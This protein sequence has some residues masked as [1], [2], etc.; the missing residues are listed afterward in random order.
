MRVRVQ[1]LRIE[2]LGR[3]K[4]NRSQKLSWYI[5]IYIYVYRCVYEYDLINVIIRICKNIVKEKE[6]V[7]IWGRF[8]QNGYLCL[9]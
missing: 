9:R 6:R 3:E 5:N 8:L 7:K 2:N 1:N 4:D